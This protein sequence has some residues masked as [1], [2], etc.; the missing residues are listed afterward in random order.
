MTGTHF[1][2]SESPLAGLRSPANLGQDVGRLTALSQNFWLSVFEL[3]TTLIDDALQVV[4]LQPGSLGRRPRRACEVPQ[5][6]CPNPRLGTV[7]REAYIGEQVRVPLRVKNKTHKART[8]QFTTEPLRNVRGEVANALE[9][10]PAQHTLAPG[11]VRVLET[12]LNVSAEVFE[13]GFDYTGDIVI[14]SEKCD[15][16]LLR[17]TLRVKSEDA[18]PLIK[19]GCPCDPPLRRVNWYDHFYCDLTGCDPTGETK[20]DRDDQL[21]RGQ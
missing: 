8:Y 13:S 11:E 16:Q 19:L 20:K 12:S 4:D 21:K 3:S 2:R 10:S 14:T 18:A 5:Y 17:F 15:P 7:V 6:P 1:Y 9:L